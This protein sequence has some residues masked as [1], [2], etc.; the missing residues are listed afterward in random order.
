MLVAIATRPD[1]MNRAGEPV[2]LHAFPRATVIG[3]ADACCP[4]PKA[5]KCA[6]G[7]VT[8]DAYAVRPRRR[9][10][11]DDAGRPRYQ[12]PAST[13]KLRSTLRACP[14][15][16]SAAADG[17]TSTLPLVALTVRAPLVGEFGRGW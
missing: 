1:S 17:G 2:T 12:T 9:C 16:R 14:P 8:L 15:M 5:I 3:M 11:Y 7:P 4:I 6:R 13:R 10:R